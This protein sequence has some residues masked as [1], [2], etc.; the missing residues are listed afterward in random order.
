MTANRALV[1]LMVF[2]VSYVGVHVV[3]GLGNVHNRLLTHIH[4]GK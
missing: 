4:G 3:T 1:W 2:A